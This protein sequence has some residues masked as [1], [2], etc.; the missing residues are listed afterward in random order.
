M[1]GL[2]EVFADLKSK[3]SKDRD[4]DLESLTN[5]SMHEIKEEKKV[6]IYKPTLKKDAPKAGSFYP[7]L[8]P[9]ESQQSFLSEPSPVKKPTPKAK[10]Q[11][12]LVPLPT[13]QDGNSRLDQIYA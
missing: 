13:G 10:K 7:T 9:S 12:A 1:L 11:M 6:N 4:D 2:E 3:V 5:M 8:G